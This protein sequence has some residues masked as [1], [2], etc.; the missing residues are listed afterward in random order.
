MPREAPQDPINTMAGDADSTL[1]PLRFSESSAPSNDFLWRLRYLKTYGDSAY[2]PPIPTDVELGMTPSDAAIVWSSLEEHVVDTQ[3]RWKRYE[4][5]TLRTNTP[6]FALASRSSVM[7][8]THNGGDAEK[9]PLPV[10]QPGSTIKIAVRQQQLEIADAAAKA[11][12][13]HQGGSGLPPMTRMGQRTATS[14]RDVRGGMSVR[15]SLP[16]DAAIAKVAHPLSVEHVVVRPEEN[17]QS[18]HPTDSDDDTV[19]LGDVLESFVAFPAEAFGDGSLDEESGGGL[20]RPPHILLPEDELLPLRGVGTD[21]P[22]RYGSQKTSAVSLLPPRLAPQVSLGHALTEEAGFF[23]PRF[24][25]RNLEQVSFALAALRAAA[26]PLLMDSSISFQHCI[27]GYSAVS[28]VGRGVGVR[29]SEGEYGGSTF[30]SS[31]MYLHHRRQATISALEQAEWDAKFIEERNQFALQQE[32]ARLRRFAQREMRSLPKC[33][34][35]TQAH[36]DTI[37]ALVAA[38]GGAS[39][40]FKKAAAAY[41]AKNRSKP[42]AKQ[43]TDVLIFPSGV[44]RGLP[45]ATPSLSG[46]AHASLAVCAGASSSVASNPLTQPEGTPAFFETAKTIPVAPSKQV[47]AAEVSELDQAPYG[48]PPIEADDVLAAQ[49]GFLEGRRG[50][51]ADL[52]RS[53]A[54]RLSDQANVAMRPFLASIS[55]PS[56]IMLDADISD[57]TR[58]NAFPAH[59]SYAMS[60]HEAFQRRRNWALSP[61]LFFL[62][63]DASFSFSHVAAMLDVIVAK[64]SVSAHTHSMPGDNAQ[65]LHWAPPGI[66]KDTLYTVAPCEQ[67]VKQVVNAF[68]DALRHSGSRQP[69][70]VLEAGGLAHP[71]TS[72]LGVKAQRCH[73][74]AASVLTAATRSSEGLCM[75]GILFPPLWSDPDKLGAPIHG[76]S[77]LNLH[78]P[79]DTSFSKNTQNNTKQTS[80]SSLPKTSSGGL[81][82][83][84]IPTVSD[85]LSSPA[86]MATLL[87]RVASG[88]VEGGT[89]STGGPTTKGSLHL[90]TASPCCPMGLL[91]KTMDDVITVYEHT[92]SGRTLDLMA[93][94]LNYYTTKRLYPNRAISAA[95]RQGEVGRREA[96]EPQRRFTEVEYNHLFLLSDFMNAQWDARGRVPPSRAAPT[97]AAASALA[98]ALEKR[99]LRLR[100][101]QQLRGDTFGPSSQV[102]HGCG[103]GELLPEALQKS[104]LEAQWPVLPPIPQPSLMSTPLMLLCSYARPYVVNWLRPVVAHLNSFFESH[105]LT[106]TFALGELAAAHD[107]AP[108]LDDPTLA[109]EMNLTA[110]KHD[111]RRPGSRRRKVDAS[112][113]EGDPKELQLQRARR[114]CRVQLYT[115]NGDIKATI[116]RLVAKVNSVEDSVENIFR[117][118]GEEAASSVPTDEPVDSHKPCYVRDLLHLQEAHIADCIDQGVSLASRLLLE[119]ASTFPPGV[120]YLVSKYVGMVSVHQLST[121]VPPLT[122]RDCL[123]SV[124]Q[125]DTTELVDRLMSAASPSVDGDQSA[126]S[127]L[128]YESPIATDAKGNRLAKLILY[129]LLI[130]P[131]LRDPLGAGI[132]APGE[133]GAS[134]KATAE[135]EGPTELFASVRSTRCTSP[136]HSMSASSRSAYSD[137]L[138]GPL[139]AAHNAPD[140]R[141]TASSHALHNF[142]AL[143]EYLYIVT[144]GPFVA[145][146]EHLHDQLRRRGAISPPSQ[147]LRVAQFI[148]DC[149]DRELGACFA[150]LPTLKRPHPVVGGIFNVSTGELVRYAPSRNNNTSSSQVLLASRRHSTITALGS[151]ASPAPSLVSVLAP[152]PTTIDV[153]DPSVPS[154]ANLDHLLSDRARRHLGITAPNQRMTSRRSSVSSSQR[155]LPPAPTVKGNAPK[156][157]PTSPSDGLASLLRSCVVVVDTSTTVP[158]TTAFSKLNERLGLLPPGCSRGTA[159]QTHRHFVSR[160]SPGYQQR[161]FVI[162]SQGASSRAAAYRFHEG[163]FRRKLGEAAPLGYDGCISVEPSS[164][165]W[166]G[167]MALDADAADALD[168]FAYYSSTDHST[169][170]ET[171]ALWEKWR[172]ETRFEVP[173]SVPPAA[174]SQPPADSP[175]HRAGRYVPN[176]IA[177]PLPA[178]PI[179][180]ACYPHRLMLVPPKVL[181]NL[182]RQALIGTRAPWSFNPSDLVINCTSSLFGVVTAAHEALLAPNDNRF[183]SAPTDGCTDVNLLGSA[184]LLG[185]YCGD[186]I[187]GRTGGTSGVAE[188]GEPAASVVAQSWKSRDVANPKQMVDA[189]IQ[190]L[191]RRYGLSSVQGSALSDAN[192]FCQSLLETMGHPM[193]MGVAL[194]N[195][196]ANN[197]LLYA[198]LTQKNTSIAAAPPA[199]AACSSSSSPI[200]DMIARLPPLEE[201]GFLLNRL[202]EFCENPFGTMEEQR[203]RLRTVDSNGAVAAAAAVGGGV[204]ENDEVFPFLPSS[205]ATKQRW[206]IDSALLAARYKQLIAEKTGG[207]VGRLPLLDGDPSSSL[208]ATSP[209]AAMMRATELGQEDDDENN[210]IKMER[211]AAEALTELTSNDPLRHP[212]YRDQITLDAPT[213]A[214]PAMA[215]T[216]ALASADVSRHHTPV[217]P[218]PVPTRGRFGTRG[219][220]PRT[221]GVQP[222][223]RQVSSSVEGEAEG[224]AL[225]DR[226]W[227]YM[228]LAQVGKVCRLLEECGVRRDGCRSNRTRLWEA[229]CEAQIRKSVRTRTNIKSSFDKVNGRVPRARR[230][231]DDG[232]TTSSDAL[233]R[234]VELVVASEA[235][236][237]EAQL[238]AVSHEGPQATATAVAL[239]GIA[240]LG[241]NPHHHPRPPPKK[242]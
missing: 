237:K 200:S 188:D 113:A 73:D 54:F 215:L 60:W 47:R 190:L 98:Q 116:D 174:L 36:L 229:A 99:L 80:G 46:I 75:Q 53:G 91:Q 180:L 176:T 74:A 126:S 97:L 223:G 83:A 35:F 136:T 166:D 61:F 150:G 62:V 101:A 221:V 50:E 16:G 127:F 135:P 27:G 33:M 132:L 13:L 87:R 32:N 94:L 17:A 103:S 159:S 56:K 85:V 157:T 186:V 92:S 15:F 235:V 109:N 138:A 218:P 59:F 19:E 89:P 81:L 169:T 178:F 129:D 86:Q 197:K 173:T 133:A 140:L 29:D 192:P 43:I 11:S 191:V 39:S 3:R 210:R 198:A 18:Q 72:T 165:L 122:L 216:S 26:W 179:E 182:Q 108:D 161:L 48:V 21:S 70:Q 123:A 154:E 172:A 170:A 96:Y 141:S 164:F 44:P 14:S 131:I 88:R 222:I 211:L 187:C 100:S 226:W 228:M 167:G 8:P 6:S 147:D 104:L 212:T 151:H 112:V 51:D 117:L 193:F 52:D 119:N 220:A 224:S 79:S 202:R 181:K 242:R 134:Q 139:D 115:S 168:T 144:H 69:P 158:L 41:E 130:L 68:C 9:K 118:R 124:A 209:L 42:H 102:A 241:S 63:R 111:K 58:F 145:R 206:F 34:L 25:D 227:S 40:V 236:R 199:V 201:I 160:A 213:F 20:F 90:A 77:Q 184:S 4:T 238:K 22:L 114:R 225:A 55:C 30:L 177:L 143:S 57:T 125:N 2:P 149:Y 78:R 120:R 7:S 28:A 171:S 67:L 5:P 163:S 205:L 194:D 239:R 233:H 153:A 175:I 37:R 137:S 217:P 142:S 45:A 195:V 24:H 64:C 183:D 105:H 156:T 146:R 71:P 128:A 12:G 204:V 110:S 214:P 107:E 82:V 93:W 23:M 185:K 231:F 1:P 38:S 95:V 76:V 189:Y 232:A 31:L 152:S 121:L 207:V 10:P 65:G 49:R 234:V 208:T 230:G 66:D 196:A 84:P 155:A 203:M 219:A 240:S 162:G 106:S 148:N